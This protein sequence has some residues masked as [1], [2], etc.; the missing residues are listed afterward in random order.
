MCA[1]GLIL[2]REKI[3]ASVAEVARI[4]RIDLEAALGLQRHPYVGTARSDGD[5]AAEFGIFGVAGEF[6]QAPVAVGCL[7]GGERKIFGNPETP[8]GIFADQRRPSGLAKR[9]CIT[10]DTPSSG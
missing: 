3:L 9:R 6:E 1:I 4:R 8:S 5:A 10:P 7:L 2:K